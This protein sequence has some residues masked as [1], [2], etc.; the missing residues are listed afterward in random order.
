M[1]ELLREDCLAEWGEWPWPVGIV[2]QNGEWLFRFRNHK[3]D[4]NPS[5]I[6]LRYYREPQ[7]NGRHGFGERRFYLPDQMTAQEL[8]NHLA[9][10]L[11]WKSLEPE[12]AGVGIDSGFAADGVV[13]LDR[14]VATRDYRAL[15]GREAAQRSDLGM[16]SLVVSVEG[17]GKTTAH[18][19]IIA[20]EALNDALAH[21][22]GIERFAGFAFRSRN[23]ANEKAREFGRTHP[24]RVIKTFWEHYADACLAEGEAAIP[25]DV[26]EEA[27]PSDILHRIRDSQPRVFARLER[28][29]AAR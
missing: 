2:I 5:T 20:N 23:Q 22:D 24:V 26:F 8:G 21:D 15:L 13:V 7:L 14:D 16:V 1:V 17:V 3:D 6:V 10:L 12:F 29:R 9:E 27:R 25:R 4:R 19:P 28:A 11:G 18:L